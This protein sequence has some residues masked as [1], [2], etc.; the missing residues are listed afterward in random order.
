MELSYN[1]EG[2]GVHRRARVSDPLLAAKTHV[3]PLRSRVVNRPRLVQRLNEGIAPNNR[4]TLISAPAGYGK[5]TL[6]GEWVSQLKVPV[7][8]LSLERAENMPVRF[9][10]YFV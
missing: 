1:R 10:S 2:V 5:S 7:A 3:P 6:L 9:W 4:I 8:W